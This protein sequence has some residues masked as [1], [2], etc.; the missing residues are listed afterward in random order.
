MARG[1]YRTKSD[2]CTCC[3]SRSKTVARGNR[4]NR[5]YLCADCVSRWDRVVWDALRSACYDTAS[6]HLGKLDGDDVDDLAE[7][8][9]SN[10]IAVSITK[11][12]NAQTPKTEEPH[13]NQTEQSRHKEI[14]KV[15]GVHPKGC[16]DRGRAR[17]DSRQ[18]R[19]SWQPVRWNSRRSGVQRVQPVANAQTPIYTRKINQ[20]PSA[21]WGAFLF[22]PW[23]DPW[24]SEQEAHRTPVFA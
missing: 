4:G 18:R 3:G 5:C 21:V 13:A 7:E 11:E 12:H 1:N 6:D 9:L 20:Q 19:D 16:L 17:T 10:H 2:Q 15:F 8:I 23:C 22:S 14:C 24:P